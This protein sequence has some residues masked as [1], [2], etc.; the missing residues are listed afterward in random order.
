MK[1]TKLQIKQIIKENQ[2]IGFNPKK[3]I[4]KNS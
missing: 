2:S 3:K 4:K 1:L